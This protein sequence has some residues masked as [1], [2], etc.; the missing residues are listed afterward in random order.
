MASR[1]VAK[2]DRCGRAGD[3][4]EAR[5]KMADSF[6]PVRGRMGFERATSAND[7]AATVNPLTLP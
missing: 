7:F 1:N 3:E 2:G 6:I 4:T 5:L